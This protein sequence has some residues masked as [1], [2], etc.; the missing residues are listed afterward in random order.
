M[1]LQEWYVACL[2]SLGVAGGA[3]L[4][5][6]NAG[7]TSQENAAA[8]PAE[9]DPGNLRAFVEL[10]RSDIKTQKAFILAQNMELTEAEAVDFWPLYEQYSHD[11]DALNDQRLAMIRKYL[12]T[13]KTL[14][15]EQAR[16]LAAEF[17]SLEEK[18][19]ALKRRYFQEFAKVIT[20]RKAVRF[21]QIE[22][23]LNA[24]IDLRLAASLPL[25]K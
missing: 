16:Q 1:K 23:Q 24:A 8:V 3:V 6:A 19:T 21:F 25:I 18:K 13:D 20:A 2:L 10:V 11:L 17:L 9:P 15:E 12:V 4:V 5:S 22:N 7:G 14:T